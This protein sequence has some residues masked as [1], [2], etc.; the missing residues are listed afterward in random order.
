MRRLDGGG[1]HLI[2]S[3]EMC[4]RSN[5]QG[6][7]VIS[8]RLARAG[9]RRTQGACASPWRRAAKSAYCAPSSRMWIWVAPRLR[10][11]VAV[12]A[13][14]QGC[15]LGCGRCNTKVFPNVIGA[16]RHT[17]VQRLMMARFTGVG[18]RRLS[19]RSVSGIVVSAHYPDVRVTAAFAPVVA[20]HLSRSAWRVSAFRLMLLNL[21]V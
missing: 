6:L 20:C 14:V 16:G 1:R 11:I 5:V 7:D 10:R 13:G 19:Y 15:R 18:P 17:A 21:L 2:P 4:W 3:H 9:I 8:Q 12:R